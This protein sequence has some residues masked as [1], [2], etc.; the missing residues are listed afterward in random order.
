MMGR[1]NLFITIISLLWLQLDILTWFVV[2]KSTTPQTDAQYLTTQTWLLGFLAKLMLM[3]QFCR[4]ANVQKEHPVATMSWLFDSIYWIVFILY[5][6]LQTAVLLTFFALLAMDSTLLREAMQGY[7]ISV[8]ITWNHLRHVTP[9]FFYL[10]LM[11]CMAP[12][13][14]EWCAAGPTAHGNDDGNGLDPYK[15]IVA[16]LVV[17]VALIMGLLHHGLFPDEDLYKYRDG[18][19]DVGRNCALVFAISVILA[20]YYFVYGFL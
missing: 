20:T 7:S 5:G 12:R 17:V 18:H 8:I 13:F 10:M 16:N 3:R 6:A 1:E 2:G 11:Q 14:R 19:P 4:S 9:V 15:F